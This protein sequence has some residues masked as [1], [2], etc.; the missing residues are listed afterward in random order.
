MSQLTT[1]IAFLIFNRPDCTAQ[2]FDRIREARPRTLLVVA[3]GP[4]SDRPDDIANC[5]AARAVVEHGVDW[6]CDTF[7]NYADSN[8]GCRGRVSSG[9][10][11][12]FNRVEEAII[13]EDD[14]LPHP[15][16]FR[17]CQE[18]LEFYRNDMRV[19]MISGHNE[20][21]DLSETND[22]KSYFFSTNVHIWAWATWRRAWKFY[23]VNMRAWPAARDGKWLW[24]VLTPEQNPSFWQHMLEEVY[25]GRNDT[26][27][28]QW[29]FACWMQ[30]GLSILPNRNL[31]LNIGFSPDA[32]H[33][34]DVAAA[35]AQRPV[36]EMPFPLRHQHWMIG[37]ALLNYRAVGIPSRTRHLLRMLKARI[38]RSTA[39]AH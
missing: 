2:A 20:Q 17:F 25:C 7:F 24:D 6:D 18:L 14:C 36:F 26:W 37:N 30:R 34:T 38:L 39:A 8:L 10:D 22:R 9:L 31:V 27:D 21:S 32:T 3:D 13:L 29:T 33:T 4:R 5:R 1:P 15:S 11:W 28:W 12:V 16:F 19:M 35:H 23:D